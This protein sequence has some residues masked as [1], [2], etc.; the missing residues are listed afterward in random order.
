LF[1]YIKR[2]NFFRGLQ[3][4]YHDKP[5]YLSSF[6]AALFYS[7]NGY[8]NK[9]EKPTNIYELKTLFDEYILNRDNAI[10]A[11]ITTDQL[12]FVDILNENNYNELKQHIDHKKSAVIK[13]NKD[14]I[15]VK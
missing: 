1:Y 15:L 11:Y 14:P 8:L 12:I 10:C 5:L 4:T 6:S 3:S 9:K 2:Y 7:I 13:N